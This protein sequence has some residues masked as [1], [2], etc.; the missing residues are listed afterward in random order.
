MGAFEVFE[1]FPAD[2]EGMYQVVGVNVAEAVH[3][4]RVLVVE[5]TYMPKLTTVDLL[6]F[7]AH[8]HY[9]SMYAVQ[10][11]RPGRPCLDI[12]GACQAVAVPASQDQRCPADKE[13]TY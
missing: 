5:G 1:W 13:F 6:A 8:L 12:G 4:I 10:E 7:S 9:I 3:P 11:V 2:L